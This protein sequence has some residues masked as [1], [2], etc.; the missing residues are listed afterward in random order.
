MRHRRAAGDAAEICC[1][2]LP[3]CSLAL[4]RARSMHTDALVL[5]C[6]PL[7]VYI[8]AVMARD[9]IC[10]VPLFQAV[11]QSP[12]AFFFFFFLRGEQ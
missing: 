5:L 3:M 8:F 4:K 11:I 7:C 1:I 12:V 10:F 2:C 9:R 6:I